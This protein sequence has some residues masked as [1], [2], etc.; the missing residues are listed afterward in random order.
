VQRCQGYLD[1]EW[2]DFPD[3]WPP[4]GAGVWTSR[5]P[6]GCWSRWWR[7]GRGNRAAS[8]CHAVGGERV[9]ITGCSGFSD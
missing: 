3:R 6:S 8:G 4:P 2:S 1:A 5:A 9:A 7:S